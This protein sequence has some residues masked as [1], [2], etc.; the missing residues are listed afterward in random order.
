M[1]DGYFDSEDGLSLY[2]REN[3]VAGARAHALV[4]HG[5]SEHYGRY[6]W[7]EAELARAGIGFSMMDLRGH[8]QS[9]GT[10]VHIDSFE[11]YLRDLDVLYK[12][13]QSHVGDTPLFLIGHS[14]GGLIA[15][16]W[17]ETR[18]PLAGKL[19]GLVTS[20]AACKA[21]L[22]PPA[23]VFF[24]LAQINRLYSRMPLPGLVPLA[25]IC[26]DPEIVRRYA[27][28]PLVN[29]N[30]TT[31]FGIASMKAMEAAIAEAHRIDIP[32]LILHGGADA[33]VDSSAS[34]ELYA[35]LRV[36]DKKLTIY[37]GHFHELFNEP[38]RES[39]LADVT[40]WMLARAGA[41]AGAGV[42]AA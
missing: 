6:R 34:S 5:V 25:K 37:P 35:G 15:V 21:T 42:S 1:R 2:F 28:D 29:K 36:A 26:R 13:V 30:L 33:L 17:A 23:P 41:R 19:R 7:V 11:Q 22:K 9:E 40:A 32:A 18:R 38:E 31:G 24:M 20:G 3:V 12:H 8:G 16:R 10:R 39:V 27:S 4:V 14:L